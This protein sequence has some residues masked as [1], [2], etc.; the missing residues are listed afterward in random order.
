MDS[1]RQTL[2]KKKRTRNIICGIFCAI[3]LVVIVVVINIMTG[4]FSKLFK[5]SSSQDNL[6]DDSSSKNVTSTETEKPSMIDSKNHVFTVCIDAGHGGN[7]SGT[8]YNKRYEK[9]DTL[10]MSLAVQDYLKSQ[11]VKVIM[12]RT[13]DKYIKVEDRSKIANDAKADYLVAIHRNKGEGDGIETWINSKATKENTD[14]A[15]NIM[16]GLATVGVQRNRG[17]RNGTEQNA[18]KDYSINKISN[19]PACIVELGFINNDK[20]NQLFDSNLKAYA[21]AIGDGIIKTYNTYKSNHTSNDTSSKASDSA[22]S[23]EATTKDDAKASDSSSTSGSTSRTIQNTQI[24]N[25]A[26]LDNK[27][28]N[29]GPGTQVDDKNRPVSAKSYQDK[30]AKYN[31]NFIG[32]GDHTIYLSFDEGYEYGCTPSILDTLK[33]KNVHAVFFVTE[34]YAKADPDLVKRM[35]SEGHE[36]G[37]HSV[38]HPAK[39]LPTETIEQQQNEVLGNHKYIKDNF[40]YDMH[41]FRYPVGI[42]SEQSLAII[43]NCNYKS[44]FWSFAYLDYDVNHQPDQGEALKKLVDHLHPGAI[45]LLHAESKT[46]TAILGSFIDKARAAGYEFKIFDN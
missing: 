34:P 21:K 20:D 42:F 5:S 31:A 25:V 7:D 40:G 13:T 30:Y 36:V 16:N 43:N 23:T 1:K 37:N 32:D 33:E 17:V 8:D 9:D 41:L 39:G 2:K 22:T 38:T 11:N 44:V 6:A 18:S 4:A 12:T 15:N 45:F 24:P 35:I 28:Q 46:N 14:L 26:S 10:K 27:I 19:M 3:L 29:W